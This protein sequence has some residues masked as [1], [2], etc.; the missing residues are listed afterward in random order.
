MVK[1][2]ETTILCM[3]F[4]LQGYGGTLRGYRDVLSHNI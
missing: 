1:R 4:M 3:G 2:M